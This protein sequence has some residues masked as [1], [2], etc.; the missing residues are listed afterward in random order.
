MKK[1]IYETIVCLLALASVGFAI[2]DLSGGMTKAMIMID[3]LIYVFFLIE[4]VVRLITSNNK[5]QFFKNNIFDLI[6]IIPF[7]SAFRIFR[8]F[9]LA[10]LLKLTKLLKATRFLALF[11]RMWNKANTFLSTNGFKYMLL[12]SCAMIGIGGIS[13][14]FAEGMSIP[15]GIWW[16]FVTATTVGYGDIS[17]STLSGRIIACLLMICGIGLIGSLTS[18]ITS[19]FMNRSPSEKNDVNNEKIKMTLM[20]YNELNESEKKLFKNKIE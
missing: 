9:K 17:P 8:T 7:S 20:L 3:G 13:I 12:L 5:K 10:R 19:F 14:S 4:Y 11:G 18:A 15:D 16:A 1:N 6:A 2:A